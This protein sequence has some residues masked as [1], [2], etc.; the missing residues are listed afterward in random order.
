MFRRFEYVGVIGEN[1]KYTKTIEHLEHD[2]SIYAHLVN[3]TRKKSLY[4]TIVAD[5]RAKRIS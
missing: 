5:W 4:F 3:H 1:D 2:T